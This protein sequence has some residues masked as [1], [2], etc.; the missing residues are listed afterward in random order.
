MSSEC[1]ANI[2]KAQAL[3]EEGNAR[4]KEGDYAK[5]MAAYHQVRAVTDVSHRHIV[6]P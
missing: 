1:A 2:A 4:F 3:K 5:A 6:C